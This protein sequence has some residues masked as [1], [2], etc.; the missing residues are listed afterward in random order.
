MPRDADNRILGLMSTRSRESIYGSSIRAS[1]ERAKEAR[2]KA[3]L[4]ACEACN[5]RMLGYQ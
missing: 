1:A 2:K 5:A 4:L 3:D